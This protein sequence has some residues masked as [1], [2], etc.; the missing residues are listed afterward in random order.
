LETLIQIILNGASQLETIRTYLR[1]RIIHLLQNDDTSTI[2]YHWKQAGMPIDVMLTECI[3]NIVA[4]TLFLNIFYKIIVEK[5]WST[6]PSEKAQ[7]W[8]PKSSVPPGIP[9]I[10]F[11][12]K[13]KEASSIECC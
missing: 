12:Q 5:A 11:I 1:K 7:K 4:F 8:L 13:Y 10:D 6:N 3:H 2:F 9:S